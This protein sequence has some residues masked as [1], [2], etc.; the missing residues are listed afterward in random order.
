MRD[1]IIGLLDELDERKLKIVQIFIRALI[2]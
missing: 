2:G 1:S